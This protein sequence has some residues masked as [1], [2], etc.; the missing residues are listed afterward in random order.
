[1]IQDALSLLHAVY[2]FFPVKKKNNN[3]P[4]IDNLDVLLGD[5]VNISAAM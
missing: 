2:V 1:M 3:T 5:F 4:Y